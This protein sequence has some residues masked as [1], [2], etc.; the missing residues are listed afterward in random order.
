MTST[1]SAKY[2]CPPRLGR[3]TR[4]LARCTRVSLHGAQ[5]F[6]QSET[7]AEIACQMQPV[8]GAR[9][10]MV[11]PLGLITSG[12]FTNVLHL[13]RNARDLTPKP[14]TQTTYNNM[15][16]VFDTQGKRDTAAEY[17]EKCLDIRLRVLGPGSLQVAGTLNGLGNVYC[18]Q[19]RFREA[20]DL[21]E[22][23]VAIKVAFPRS[24]R[25]PRCSHLRVRAD[26][27]HMR[28][29]CSCGGRQLLT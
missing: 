1:S 2:M 17:N 4:R 12:R 26:S 29:L 24:M 28:T 23:S 6:S 8:A 5:C 16:I 9:G 19:G 27:K 13:T 3:H 21:L 14:S 7:E 20:L 22:R 15:A 11:M 10:L 18:K 25:R